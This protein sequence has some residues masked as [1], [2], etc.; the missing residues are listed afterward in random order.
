MPS[1]K[2]STVLGRQ[3]GDELRRFREAAGFSTADAAEFLD[4]TKGKMPHRERSCAGP[5]T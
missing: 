5:Y 3:L 2:P 4:C 1:V